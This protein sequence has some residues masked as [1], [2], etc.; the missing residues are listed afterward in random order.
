M[1]TKSNE[2]V[3]KVGF[4]VAYDWE[5]LKNSLPRIYTY[6]DLICLAVDK[7]RKSWSG[8]S[9]EFNDSSFYAFVKAI[10]VHHKIVIYE[11]SFFLPELNARENCNR[12]R[13]LIAKKMGSGGWHIQVDCDE[14][15]LNFNG[16]VQYLKTIHPNPT[17]VEKPLNVNVCLVPLYKKTEDGYL[18]V[19]FKKS[20]PENAPF[21]T[22]KPEYLRARNNGH[23]S[24]LSRFYAI[25]ETWARSESELWYK[26]NNWGH[27]AEELEGTNTR[28]T[29]FNLWK[30]LNSQNHQNISNVHPATPETWPA[31]AFCKGQTIEEFIRN[32]KE[33]AFPLNHFQLAFRNNRNVARIRSMISRIFG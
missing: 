32:F 26:L 3:V 8:N 2:K 11:E 29:Y 30:S 16:F 25:H 20:I 6:A 22:N 15:F 19:N 18:Y 10:D 33:P 27:S 7:D 1:E 13:T 24:I 5:L 14:Y 9:F 17:G 21:A 31:L 12:Q 4:C 23:F 28:Q